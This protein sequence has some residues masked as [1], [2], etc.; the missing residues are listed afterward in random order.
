MGCGRGKEGEPGLDSCRRGIRRV[1]GE[2]GIL[3][4][5]LKARI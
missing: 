4:N 1:A 2:E 5:T 3:E